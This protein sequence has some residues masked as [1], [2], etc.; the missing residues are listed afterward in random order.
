MRLS[1]ILPL[2]G[3]EFS[4]F[5][6]LKVIWVV[7]IFGVL[8][9][10]RLWRVSLHRS[11]TTLFLLS[12]SGTSSFYAARCFSDPTGRDSIRLFRGMKSTFVCTVLMQNK[13]CMWY[14]YTSLKALNISGTVQISRWLTSVKY[15]FWLNFRKTGILFTKNMLHVR[16]TSLYN[17]INPKGIFTWSLATTFGFFWVVFPLSSAMLFPH[18]FYAN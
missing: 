10:G 5:T 16:K 3:K 11:F 12:I 17:F 7:S 2:V 6:V 15:V 1:D 4:I 13:Q 18:T 8:W 14:C 9:K